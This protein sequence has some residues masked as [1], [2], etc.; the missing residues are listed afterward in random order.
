MTNFRIHVRKIIS[1]IL[2]CLILEVKWKFDDI[3]LI[4]FTKISTKYKCRENFSLHLFNKFDNNLALMT[5]MFTKSYVHMTL[6]KRKYI[7]G[8]GNLYCDVHFQFFTLKDFVTLYAL[9]CFTFMSL[10]IISHHSFL[11]LI[12]THLLFHYCVNCSSKVLPSHYIMK[13]SKLVL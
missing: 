9:F 10:P 3:I 12:S 1:K 13:H 8:D 4:C 2:I 5:N 6:N 11:L 7:R